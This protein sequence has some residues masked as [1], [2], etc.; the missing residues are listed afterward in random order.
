METKNIHEGKAAKNY[1]KGKGYAM[2]DV[3]D[4]LEMTEQGLSKNFRMEKLTKVFILKIN[5]ALNIDIDKAIHTPSQRGSVRYKKRVPLIG[6]AVAGT[7]MEVVV[8]DTP[9]EMEY[10]DVGDM[11][12][13]SE[14]AFTVYGNSMTP[15]YPS[16]CILG[17]RRNY[18]NFIQPGEIYLLVTRSNRVFKRL[19]YNE[20]KTGFMCY[21]DN[22][23]EYDKGS[24]KGRPYYPPFE[25]KATDVVSVYDV[26][27]LIKR[28]RNSAVIMRQT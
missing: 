14:A 21:S 24:L 22:T 13:D 28:T 2:K 5:A 11:L 18:D 20:D 23:I 4:K 25:V 26:V 19:Y 27:G 8:D 12:R 6:D 9:A 3:A 10:I 15:G 7:H 17:I 1:L 16:G